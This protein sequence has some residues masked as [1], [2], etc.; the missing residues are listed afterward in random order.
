ME[1]VEEVK[2]RW[3]GVGGAESAPARRTPRLGN[4]LQSLPGRVGG[5]SPVTGD[6]LAGGGGVAGHWSLVTGNWSLPPRHSN[7]ETGRYFN[8]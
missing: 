5:W 4:T 1:T 6:R 8:I 3:V 2:S 7:T